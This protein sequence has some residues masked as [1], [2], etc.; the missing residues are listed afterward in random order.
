MKDKLG[1]PFWSGSKHPPEVINYDPKNELHTMF[2]RSI[3]LLLCKMLKIQYT[4]KDE[5]KIEEAA[6]KYNCKTVELKKDTNIIVDEKNEK[7]IMEKLK[8][9]FTAEDEKIIDDLFGK[10]L[11]G[12]KHWKKEDIEVIPFEKDDDL[13]I[14]FVHSASIIRANN[15]KLKPCE[16]S[17]TKFIAGRIIPAMATTTAVIVGA[18]LGELIKYVQGFKDLAL[19]KCLNI[20]MAINFYQITLPNAPRKIVGKNMDPMY[21]NQPTCVFPEECTCWTKIDLKGPM[22]I[23][24]I[25]AKLEKEYQVT[26]RN[27]SCGKRQLYDANSKSMSSRISKTVEEIYYDTK[28]RESYEKSLELLFITVVKE[29]KIKALFPLFKY[30]LPNMN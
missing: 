12:I 18:V 17:R 3:T 5:L 2:V 11:G 16:K 9:N 10:I 14:D 28:K 13:I 22:K 15:Y 7:Q 29:T 8:G 1:Q 19:Y 20:N 25:L 4:E 24:E 6:L 27:I 23:G 26:V 30:E 21:N